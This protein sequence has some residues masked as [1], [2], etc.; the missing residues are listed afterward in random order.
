[1]SDKFCTITLSRA[2]YVYMMRLLGNH[3]TGQGPAET[4]YAQLCDKPI[5]RWKLDSQDHFDME[6]P[7][8]T[9]IYALDVNRPMV[10]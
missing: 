10:R 3:T 6:K 1:M 7:L 8:E 4:I 5:A 2:E 9:A